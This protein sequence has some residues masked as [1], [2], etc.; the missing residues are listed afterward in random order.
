MLLGKDISPVLMLSTIAVTWIFSEWDYISKPT[1]L[2]F[3]VSEEAEETSS[4][5]II[6]S[7]N[8]SKHFSRRF[9]ENI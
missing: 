7:P 9:C 4:V 8:L 1:F 3:L 2:M 5:S 6:I